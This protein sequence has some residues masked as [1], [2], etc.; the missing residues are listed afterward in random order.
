MLP[1]VK[2]LHASNVFVNPSCGTHV[3]FYRRLE[4]SGEEITEDLL[5]ARLEPLL[6]YLPPEQL[7]KV[8]C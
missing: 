4:L 8:C 2:A 1:G 6:H 5:W 7:A 3:Q